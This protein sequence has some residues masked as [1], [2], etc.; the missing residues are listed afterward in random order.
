MSNLSILEG[1]DNFLFD[2]NTALACKSFLE[3]ENRALKIEIDQMLIEF[4]KKDEV[5]STK[6]EE[7]SRLI[8]STSSVIRSHTSKIGDIKNELRASTQLVQMKYEVTF[9]F[10]N[11]DK[12]IHGID[13]DY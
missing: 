2:V 1:F 13:T 9:L 7:I 10:C 4:K 5:I 12:C 11:Q 6:E 8:E 3:E